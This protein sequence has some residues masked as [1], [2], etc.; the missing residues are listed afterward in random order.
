MTSI[1]IAFDYGKIRRLP[2]R[3]EKRMF[4]ETNLHHRNQFYAIGTEVQKEINPA[5]M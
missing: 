1:G 3:P 2:N 4:P 5:E